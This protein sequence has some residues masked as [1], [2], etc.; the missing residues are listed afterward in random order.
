MHEEKSA[1]ETSKRTLE[2]GPGR[3]QSTPMHTWWG[4]EG[5]LRRWQ[6]LVTLGEAAT[7]EAAPGPFVL[8][9]WLLTPGSAAPRFGRHTPHLGNGVL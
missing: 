3:L 5:A 9:R 1:K 8:P 2:K 4:Q 7:P 6:P